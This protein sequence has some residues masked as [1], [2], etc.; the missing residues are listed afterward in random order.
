MSLIEFRN[1][2]VSL[3]GAEIL[4]RINATFESG[5]IH[6]IIGRNGSGKSIMFKALCGFINISNGEIAV[7]GKRIGM[8]IDHP[9]SVGVMINDCG[10]LPRYSGYK[11]LYFIARIRNV[12]SATDIKA[13]IALVGLNPQDRKHVAKYSTGMRQRLAIA[14]AVMENPEL[15][16]LDEPLNGLDDTGVMEIREILIKLREQGK[17]IM[18]ASHNREDIETLCDT[19][20]KMDAG[21]LERVS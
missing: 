17:T 3:G 14:Q 13:A 15:L 19:V 1:V 9:E 20:H 4:K 12:I 10:F 5:K 18:L 11:N 16:V 21:V 6:G 7:N 2:S 8:D